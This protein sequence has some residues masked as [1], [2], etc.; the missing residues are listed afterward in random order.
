MKK[1]IVALALIPTFILLYAGG[2]FENIVLAV[3]G[4]AMM[5]FEMITVIIHKK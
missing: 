2:N 3:A 5:L 1:E 4:I